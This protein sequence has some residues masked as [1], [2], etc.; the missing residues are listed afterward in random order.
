MIKKILPF[1]ILLLCLAVTGCASQ[2]AAIPTPIPATP[3]PALDADTLY[4]MLIKAL[5]DSDETEV[6][7]LITAGAPIDRGNDMGITPLM[8]AAINEDAENIRLLLDAGADPEARTL[9]GLTALI[10]VAQQGKAKSIRPLVEGGAD[11]EGVDDIADHN[12]TPLGWAAYLGQVEVVKELIVLGANLNYIPSG[13]GDTPVISAVR[14]YRVEVVK[15]LVEAKADLTIRNRMGKTALDYAK[16]MND[17]E[18]I[19]LLEAAGA[20]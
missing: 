1:L 11:I 16:E 9:N 20:P 4:E 12:N 10:M 17:A 18:M 8:I 15:V 5:Q 7:R 3:T 6:A 19:A 2:A 14:A 13:Q